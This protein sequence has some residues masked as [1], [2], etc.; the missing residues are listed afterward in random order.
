[1]PLAKSACVGLHEM[2]RFV[3]SLTDR[4]ASD[5]APWR[6]MR[7]YR[8]WRNYSDLPGMVGGDPSANHTSSGP[9][10]TS[11]SVSERSEDGAPHRPLLPVAL[12]RLD[13]T[14][15]SRSLWSSCSTQGVNGIMPSTAIQATAS[16]TFRV[17]GIKP[18]PV[19]VFAKGGRKWIVASEVCRILGLRTDTVPRLVPEQERSHATVLTKGSVQSVI[20]ITEEGFNL[21][22]LR[23]FLSLS[24]MVHN[25]NM[26]SGRVRQWL[27]T[28]CSFRR[29]S[30]RRP[31]R[32]STAPR[33]NAGRW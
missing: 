8:A 3:G 4:P 6:G 21:S 12:G 7:G 28:K 16:V 18:S 1:M 14:D 30:V 2:P 23:T 33:R 15:P 19:H 27:G 20:T 17:S 29:A 11:L 10:D 9:A 32:R 25:V 5:R 24:G 22:C 26:K 31:S 13:P